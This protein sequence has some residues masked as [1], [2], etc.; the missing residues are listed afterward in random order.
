MKKKYVTPMIAVEHYELTQTIAN[1]SVKIGFVDSECVLSDPDAPGRMKNMA[2]VS[3]FHSSMS[4]YDGCSMLATGTSFEDGI[5][6]H[7]STSM[8]FNS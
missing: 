6:Y 5:C 4:G 7:T 2:K 8:T 3:F 1:C